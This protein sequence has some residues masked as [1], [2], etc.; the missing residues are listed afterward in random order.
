MRV[1]ELELESNYVDLL[2]E[3]GAECAILG[4]PPII[5]KIECYKVIESSGIFKLFCAYF[6]EKLIG[7]VT[8]LTPI[9]PHYG[10]V[11]AVAESLFVLKEY[12]GS[13]AG[14]RLI[15]VAIHHA[16]SMTSTGIL[17]SSPIGGTL[18]KVLPSLGFTATNT[19][20]FKGFG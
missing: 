7:I 4:M 1:S 16:K 3:Y 19:T 20:F 5:E 10:A 9:I 13:G 18:S 17:F 15:R 8:V 2:K 12:R 6:N 14:M 11:V